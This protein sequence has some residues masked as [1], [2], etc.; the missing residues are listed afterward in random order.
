[1]YFL[2][3]LILIPNLHPD[4][5][6]AE[7]E[8]EV[9]LSRLQLGTAKQTKVMEMAGGDKNDLVMSRSL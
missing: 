5:L 3:Q 6:L 9:P 4:D 8:D 1:M 7:E 2:F